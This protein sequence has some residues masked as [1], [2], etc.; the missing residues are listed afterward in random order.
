MEVEHWKIGTLHFVL[1]DHG[2]PQKHLI[3]QH[4]PGTTCSTE[5][6]DGEKK[7][8]MLTQYRCVDFIPL[9]FVE[10]IKKQHILSK[11]SQKW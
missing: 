5:W 1:S 11:A 2:G 8:H 3:L 4:L 6:N 10:T 9:H 7:P